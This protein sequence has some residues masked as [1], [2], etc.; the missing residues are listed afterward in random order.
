MTSV[1]TLSARDRR[2]LMLG[3]LVLVP[4][5]TWGL[6][7]RPYRDAVE[8]ASAKLAAERELL[9]RERALLAAEEGYRAGFGASAERLVDTASRLFGGADPGAAA[10]ALGEHLRRAAG[11]SRVWLQEVEPLPPEVAGAGLV[12][13]P[14]RVRGESDLEGLLTLLQWLEAGPKLI[15][16]DLLR[17]DVA[18]SPVAGVP[19]AA[20]WEN[21]AF[22]FTARGFRL[23]APGDSV[24][25]NGRAPGGGAGLRGRDGVGAGGA[26]G[27]G[28]GIGR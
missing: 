20:S 25:V 13:L 18:A 1:A 2:A 10:A 15:R 9:A 7:V 27:A 11:E 6:A 24:A 22:S 19:A 17:I 26:V 23:A 14:V 12:A 8:R 4:A 28:A 21:L 5:L 16:I 3:A